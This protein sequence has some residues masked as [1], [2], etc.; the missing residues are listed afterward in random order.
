MTGGA[1]QGKRRRH[2]HAMKFDF[3]C[4]WMGVPYDGR[5]RV[6]RFLVPRFLVPRYRFAHAHDAL[7]KR[8]FLLYSNQRVCLKQLR[9]QLCLEV[10][11]VV[12][13]AALCSRDAPLASACFSF[14][15]DHFMDAAK[16]G[17]GMGCEDDA[18]MGGEDRPYSSEVH[19][20]SPSGS[21]EVGMQML[22]RTLRR[23][24]VEVR[25]IEC[26]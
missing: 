10:L 14:S 24:L 7:L 22:V 18:P 20:R 4:A 1:E 26:R 15:L 6:P 16:V 9:R 11:L 5:S 23:F 8:I 2:A 3:N 25:A 12:F 21:S 13:D 17:I 19:N